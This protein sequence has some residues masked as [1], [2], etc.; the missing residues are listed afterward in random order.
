MISRG[1]TNSPRENRGIALVS[2]LMLSIILLAMAGAFFAAHKTDLVLMGTSLKMEETK[3]AALSAAQF[4]QYKLQNDRRFGTVAFREDFS[5]DDEVYPPKGDPLLSVEYYG[6][7]N[8]LLKNVVK[9]KL[10]S[11][12][13]EFEARV[14]NMLD[15]DSEMHTSLGVTPPRCARVWISTKRGLVTKRMDFIVK[16]SPFSGVSM[17][18]GADINVHLTQSE[19]GAW[20]LG[21]RQPSGNAVRAN[22]TINGPEVLSRAGRSV[23]FEPPEGLTARVTPPYGVMQAKELRMQM[24]GV[25]KLIDSSDPDVKTAERN[26]RGALSPEGAPVEVPTLDADKLTAPVTSFR[27]PSNKVTFKT[28]EKGGQVVHQLLEG[29]RVVWE[30]DGK[31]PLKRFY[32]WDFGNATF[33]L[34]SRT[35]TVAPGAELKTKGHFVLSSESEVPG[36]D[37]QPTLVLGD[38]YQ[39]GSLDAEGITIQGSVGGMGALKA[40]QEGLRVRAK[41]SLS[42]TPDFGV[43]LHSE[44]DVVLSKPGSSS[45]DGIPV[46]WDAYAE[47]FRSKNSGDNTKLSHW[48]ELDE[49]SK[50]ELAVD[51]AGRELAEPVPDPGTSPYEN[52]LWGAL[53]KDFPADIKASQAFA[54]WMKPGDPGEFDL[55]PVD[56]ADPA[57]PKR[58]VVV[59]E[60]VP[61]GPGLN[62]DRYV[63]LREYLKSLKAG[64]P[65]ETWLSA[66][67]PEVA[68]RRRWDV[69]KMVKNQLSS[70]QLAAGQKAVDKNGHV[71]LEW[72]TLGDYFASDK[73]NPF[74]NGFNPDMNFRGLIYAGRD[75]SFDTQKQ[76]IQ[77]EGAIVAHGDIDIRNATGAR[78]IYNSDLLE[79]L[80]STNEGDNS[81]KLDRT[82]W[83][84][85]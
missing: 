58:R 55:V 22:G 44:S 12:G 84:F 78:I 37:F 26:I 19:D 15:Q 48:A 36:H 62:V 70:F 7:G 31:N 40:G 81:V 9:G 73:K 83:A 45:Q 38:E 51:F 77:V 69:R 29:R 53:T 17:L 33:D 42:T 35:M 61:S 43:A 2:V 16:R 65:D 39:G 32:S 80:F 85:Y 41:S 28:V 1:R 75:F 52:P 74:L 30:Y 13:T 5:L 23:L 14:V 8:E 71:V 59:R 64:T 4:M 34:E 66:E 27:P 50:M 10:L 6:E 47:G 21:A 57:G 67:D 56:P 76:G 60:P 72:N 24:N 82:F 11:T 49:D 46:D 79:N 25:S 68:S 18:S 20:W 3:N 54:E 63:R